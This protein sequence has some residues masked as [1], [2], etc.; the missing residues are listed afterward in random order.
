[1]FALGSSVGDDVK[2]KSAIERALG[3]WESVVEWADYI[4]F[5]ARVQKAVKNKH[6]C[7]GSQLP[8]AENI[9]EMLA[10][11]LEP[12]LPSGVHQMCVDVYDTVFTIL[13][14]A[15]LAVT[16]NIWLPGLLPVVSWA[17][18]NIKPM[19]V[20]LFST[21]IVP[22][23]PSGSLELRELYKPIFLAMLPSIEE[24]SSDCFVEICELLATLKKKQS[25]DSH[26]WRSF[27]L[28]VLT[29]PECRL[30]ALTWLQR[31]PPN[32]SEADL[33][34]RAVCSGLEDSNVLVQRGFLDVLAK[35]LPLDGAVLES[36]KP[37]R[38]KLMW[39]SCTT[40]LRKD[41][42]LNRRLRLWL[43]GPDPDA[44]VDAAGSSRLD[45][46]QKHV[47]E[48]LIQVLLENLKL[49]FTAVSVIAR[50]LMDRWEMSV[51]LG[52]ALLEPILLRSH[53]LGHVEAS[54]KAFFDNVDTNVVW[55]TCIRLLNNGKEDVV[56]FMVKNFTI[57]DEEMIETYIPL[58]V[59]YMLSGESL[60][61]V[62]L[63]ILETLI[64]S[65]AYRPIPEEPKPVES[66]QEVRQKIFEFF[67]SSC[68]VGKEVSDD[69]MQTGPII[70]SAVSWYLLKLSGDLVLD[71][72][73][74]SPLNDILKRFPATPGLEL[75]IPNTPQLITSLDSASSDQIELF[76]FL[77][78]RKS[79]VMVRSYVQK[80]V[81]DMAESFLTN[82]AHQYAKVSKLWELSEILPNYVVPSALSLLLADQRKT[83][84]E[85]AT[86]FAE[87]WGLSIDQTNINAM[88]TK[89]LLLFL[90][91][92]KQERSTFD[93]YLQSSI[94]RTVTAP[95]A[96]KLLID[97]LDQESRG[98]VGVFTYVL[99]RFLIL[100]SNRELKT[101][102][103][104]K[105]SPLVCTLLLEW[106]DKAILPASAYEHTLELAELTILDN[107]VKD[108]RVWL[109]RFVDA[110][111]RTYVENLSAT[112]PIPV[113]LIKFL[114][115]TV[116]ILESMQDIRLFAQL[117]V[118]H[119]KT[120]VDFEAF[121]QF[122]AAISEA[123]PGVEEDLLNEIIKK[124]QIDPDT[125]GVGDSNSVLH[126]FAAVEQII[127]V[128]INHVNDLAEGVNSG[129]GGGLASALTGF[130]VE[131]PEDRSRVEKLQA[132]IDRCIRSAVLLGT[133]YWLPLQ[134]T[135]E[136]GGGG[137]GSEYVLHTT[138]RLK[139]RL[140]KLLSLCYA[141]RPMETLEVV[142][143][144]IENLKDVVKLT[145]MFEGPRSSVT[146]ELL[147][148]SAGSSARLFEFAAAYVDSLETDV[149]GDVWPIMQQFLMTQV[150]SSSKEGP[151]PAMILKFLV[152]SI[153]PR[154]D[155]LRLKNRKKVF[156]DF[157]EIYCKLIVTDLGNKELSATAVEKLPM[158]VP[159]PD[160]QASL[161]SKVFSANFKSATDLAANSTLLTKACETFSIAGSAPAKVWTRYV[162]DFVFET[163]SSES[164]MPMNVQ[165]SLSLKEVIRTWVQC[166][167]DR[168]KEF[169]SKLSVYG[170]GTGVLFGWSGTQA[171]ANSNL[172]RFAY[173][174]VCT[175]A[176]ALAMNWSK[177]MNQLANMWDQNAAAS[178]TLLRA[179]LLSQ[180]SSTLMAF[181]AFR[182][183]TVF[184][185]AIASTKPIFGEEAD[186]LVAACKL[187][188]L[189]LATGIQE[190][191]EFQWLFISDCGDMTPA[192]THSA[193]SRAARS[194]EKHARSEKATDSTAASTESGDEGPDPATHRAGGVL[195][196][197]SESPCLPKVT[198]SE[199]LSV[200][201]PQF[202]SKRRPLLPPS[203]TLY[204]IPLFLSQITLTSYEEVYAMSTCDREFCESW[205]LADLFK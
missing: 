177:L 130:Q 190:F 132:S 138:G 100:L 200:R 2:W 151:T 114:A 142:V 56:L 123:D 160:R 128:G 159:E 153:I 155:H 193:P 55:N 109:R 175:P 58:V 102:Y 63:E 150:G 111:T 194:L 205:L 105:F 3:T 14:P 116:P 26:Y 188:D 195:E 59:L 144:N 140:R 93:A 72:K 191:Q 8:L 7:D 103:I 119:L 9:S 27:Y 17:A 202:K 203:A 51:F 82:G 112:T 98:D 99:E 76:K 148:E 6:R 118:P 179:C 163:Q 170:S 131:S 71:H 31:M 87:L 182:L 69:T 137:S 73:S 121:S 135:R 90:D 18:F 198:V 196:R 157:A 122:L 21:H 46:F 5:L 35:L 117:S 78:N 38:P 83:P 167:K 156:K 42:S 84:F 174:L 4:S 10:R 120:E 165:E 15:K 13:G 95:R 41:M 36:A 136:N 25:D 107:R 97:K 48:T 125:D 146:L 162:S 176:A 187:L 127:S 186:L 37:E 16:V 126:L 154:L 199:Q 166:D 47:A 88:L 11:C 53:E 180:P 70:P 22:A 183:Q 172:K 81:N 141:H 185:R 32:T 152:H 86:I 115:A 60:N 29:S 52:P 101:V 74:A 50:G 89:P 149:L 12:S 54:V 66:K 34:I 204:D 30:G 169:V 96:L 147:V 108:G 201:N 49:D 91:I 65:L 110:L 158:I 20:K 192:S 164:L 57:T 23:I 19:V 143:D 68:T 197:L 75:A 24:E 161:L 92:S 94:V 61:D 1:M 40:I 64:A 133:Q 43:L 67:D 33:L 181:M 106:F 184:E 104:S 168:I 45:Y 134:R 77:M 145:H 79:P 173:I 139:T 44:S 28:A 80:I 124:L 171:L 85:R 189:A 113:S 178:C 39:S 62:E 129:G